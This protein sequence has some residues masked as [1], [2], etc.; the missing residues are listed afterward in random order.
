M[1]ASGYS[2]KPLL[3]K[4]GIKEGQ[5]VAILSAPDPVPDGLERMP[6]GVSLAIRLGGAPFD[7]I[8]LFTTRRADLAK[9]F[10]QA[11]R[12][13]DPAGAIWVSWPKKASGVATD[14]TEDTVREVAL[15]AGFVDNKVCAV[16]QTWS[17]LRCVLRLENRPGAAAR[18][19]KR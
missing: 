10:A 5:R 16:D 7:Q 4:L 6:S 19:K 18:A 3:A 17:G 8:L 9:R 2:G 15:P 14:I 12:A 11:A 13:L 1:T